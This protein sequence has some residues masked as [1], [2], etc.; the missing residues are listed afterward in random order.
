MAD[1]PLESNLIL[2]TRTEKPDMTGI[3]A[4]SKGFSAIDAQLKALTAKPWVITVRMTVDDTAIKAAGISM[5][6]GGSGVSGFSSGKFAV[7]PGGSILY[8][9]Q[10]TSINKEGEATTTYLNKIAGIQGRIEHT[11]TAITN[12]QGGLVKSVQEQLSLEQ[13]VALAQERKLKM[14]AELRRYNDQQAK[15]AYEGR[16][17]GAQFRLE[18]NNPNITPLNFS[19]GEVFA[20]IQASEREAA[21]RRAENQ[22]VTDAATLNEN[23]VRNREQLASDKASERMAIRSDVQQY[24]QYGR[25]VLS[26]NR[27]RNSVE[28][29]KDKAAARQAQDTE[30]E[31]YNRRVAIAKAD[32]Q[33][34][35]RAARDAEAE[36][37][38]QERAETN[39]RGRMDR[40]EARDYLS[41]IRRTSRYEGTQA[42]IAAAEGRGFTVRSTRT[43]GDVITGNLNR[44]TEAARVTGNAFTGLRVELLRFNDATGKVDHSI[45]NHTQSIKYLGDSLASS[46]SKVLNWTIATTAIFA[47]IAVITDAAKAV[48]ELEQNT[49]LLARVG[50]GLGDS[51]S[52]RIGPAKE[53]T[54]QIVELTT[55]YGGYAEAATRAATVFARAGR[56]QQEILEGVRVSLIASKIAELDVEEAAKL[57]SSAMLQFNLKAKDLLPTLDVLNTL[58]NNYRVS[59]DDL[60][61]SIS[62]A[63]SVYDDHG[64]RLS[65][66]ASLTAVVSQETSRSGAEIGNAIKTIISQL[67]RLDVQKDLFDELGISTVNF[68]G[69]S[70]SL[71][72]ILYEESLAL[73]KLSTSEQKQLTL[74]Q[75][76]IRQ[77]GILIASLK[78]SPEAIIAENKSLITKSSAETEFKEG[79]NTLVE[80][81]SRLRA[82]FV[83]FVS[84][85]S[86]PLQA[87]AHTLL[88]L[89]SSLL[90]LLNLFGGA[91]AKLLGLAA[92]FLAIRSIITGVVS[93]SN[94]LIGTNIALAT[95]YTALNISMG[96]WLA[97]GATVVVA[98]Y[99][100]ATANSEYS[101]STSEAS[102]AVEANIIQEENRRKAILDTTEAIYRLIEAKRKNSD[103]EARR[104]AGSIEIKLPAGPVTEEGLLGASRQ[105][106]QE[107]IDRQRRLAEGGI[108]LK[109]IALE[110]AKQKEYDAQYASGGLLGERKDRLSYGSEKQKNEVRKQIIK[111]TAE[112][113]QAER[114]YLEAKNRSEQLRVIEQ[115]FNP[116]KQ[117][118]RLRENIHESY[119]GFFNRDRTAVARGAGNGLSAEASILAQ[120]KDYDVLSTSVAKLATELTEAAEL[121]EKMNSESYIEAG[122]ELNKQILEQAKA[123]EAL[124]KAR[125][126]R[127]EEQNLAAFAS[128]NRLRDFVGKNDTKRTR[129]L[130][131]TTSPYGDSIAEIDALRQSQLDRLGRNAR[132]LIAGGKSAGTVQATRKDS[133][134]ALLK[135]KDLEL[136]KAEAILEAETA[137]ALERKKSADE[138]LR[139]VGA[140]SDEDKLRF[141]A[142]A[143]YFAA[144]PGKKI[145][146]EEQLN[147]SSRD[148][149]ITNSFFRSRLDQLGSG[150]AGP[151]G[152]FLAASGF[153]STPELDRGAAEVAAAR[154][155]RTD[156]ELLGGALNNANRFDEKVQ[157]LKGNEASNITDFLRNSVG[158]FSG[159]FDG[160]GNSKGERVQV[161]VSG[162]TLQLEP[163]INAFRDSVVFLMDTKVK[164]MT[165]NVQ[166]I[167]DQGK[168][169]PVNQPKKNFGNF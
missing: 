139:A 31:F 51:F 66:L 5:K 108:T 2:K 40:R 59:T 168:N 88:D 155:G 110:E 28:R 117:Q 67:D 150:A 95:S 124:N 105:A 82:E 12:A 71:T 148:I 137:I 72:K 92:A 131:Y 146:I 13:K 24:D 100:M 58:S 128:E 87:L 79:A 55:V 104:L 17:L 64:G 130:S 35:L 65:E 38:R 142:Q 85:G 27:N 111:A 114:D 125:N 33:D 118:K 49:V 135:L 3:Q 70:K 103:E 116:D 99:A 54:A 153:G 115:D 96:N 98:I 93:A 62:R 48:A 91:G 147:S 81:L 46:A 138:A 6:G 11:T 23:R 102:S 119:L 122:K 156:K 78:N 113:E 163:L 52:D 10:T 37:L 75:A 57:I 32:R 133:E 86:G 74:K 53:L 15:L 120:A 94:T 42:G 164:E 106:Q 127:Y 136:S 77:R 161:D 1:N 166:R 41:D 151:Y 44:Q 36:R 73:D 8:G 14:A 129:G 143:A 167:I 132:V 134:E 30:D 34:R 89:V 7:G 9:R 47:S 165:A 16:G 90:K 43:T 84:I 101:L 68:S 154:H 56:S 76:G 22:R 160:G 121:N 60:L 83:K 123:Y 18:R 20:R 97:I 61:Q 25:A 149:G 152:A 144:N 69:D 157:Q 109:Q 19:S 26:D 45:L 107:S 159:L 140:L 29:S 39:A 4:L 112:R 169:I 141:R 50:L 63:G 21:R 162:D 145:S 80:K 126:A 158:F